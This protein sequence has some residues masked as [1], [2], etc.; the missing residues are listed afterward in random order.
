MNLKLERFG[1]AVPRAAID[2]F[3]LKAVAGGAPNA[4]IA[5]RVAVFWSAW[6]AL[7]P[8]KR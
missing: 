1:A 5:A 8:F 6:Q 7:E 2:Y 3:V 4:A